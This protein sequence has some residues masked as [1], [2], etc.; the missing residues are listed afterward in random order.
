MNVNDFIPKDEIDGFMFVANITDREIALHYMTNNQN[1]FQQALNDYHNNRNSNEEAENTIDLTMSPPVIPDDAESNI[2]NDNSGVGL[3]MKQGGL[4]S[5]EGDEERVDLQRANRKNSSTTETKSVIQDQSNRQKKTKTDINDEVNDLA[6]DFSSKASTK[7]SSDDSLTTKKSTSKP[8]SIQE[9]FTDISHTARGI[10]HWCLPSELL[11]QSV[12][13]RSQVD[14][15]EAIA[16][17]LQQEEDRN[18]Q[19]AIQGARH[20]ERYGRPSRGQPRHNNENEEGTAVDN[21]IELLSPPDEN[22]EGIAVPIEERHGA[23]GGGA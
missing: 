23:I 10:K 17:A 1:N 2:W 13:A 11:L 14:D 19:G 3:L 15:D 5:N 18:E 22:E 20:G 21:A 12:A 6:A 8:K 7:S 4:S 9:K 16:R